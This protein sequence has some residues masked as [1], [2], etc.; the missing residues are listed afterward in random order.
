MISHVQQQLTGML[1]VVCLAA[2]LAQSAPFVKTIEFTQ[3][4]GTAIKL[5]G[6]GD[7]F[8]ADFERRTATRFSSTTRAAPTSMRHAHPAGPNSSPAI[9]LWEA[10]TLRHTACPNTC[11][12]IPN[13]SKKKDRN[14]T[15]VGTAS[16]AT[17]NAGARA[18]PPCK[19]SPP[20]PRPIPPRSPRPPFE[21]IA[22]AQR[23]FNS[24]DTREVL[25]SRF[26]ELNARFSEQN[27]NRRGPPLVRPRTDTAVDNQ[28]SE[29][30]GPRR[31]H[32]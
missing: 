6:Q 4:D 30:S 32:S 21:N 19:A 1:A 17:A 20:S 29:P 2:T 14:A 10:A 7:E 9:G 31:H 18:K 28:R 8:H 5:V 15:T 22:S 23:Y 26:P 13:P 24:T 3:P 11:E 27:N 25:Q 16:P 12:A